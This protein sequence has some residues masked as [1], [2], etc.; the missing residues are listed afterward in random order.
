M[1]PGAHGPLLF[2]GQFSFQKV[3]SL[4]EAACAQQHPGPDIAV[5]DFLAVQFLSPLLQGHGLVQKPLVGLVFRHELEDARLFPAVFLIPVFQSL[6]Q[7]VGGQHGLDRIQV[8]LG[9]SL[10]SVAEL[11]KILALQED[12]P[13]PVQNLQSLLEHALQAQHFPQVEIELGIACENSFR[14]FLQVSVEGVKSGQAQHFLP[15]GDEHSCRALEV[16]RLEQVE[17]GQVRF[18]H[19]GA[20][21]RRAPMQLLVIV[22]TPTLFVEE[23]PHQMVVAVEIRGQHKDKQALLVQAAED[24]LAVLAAQELVADIDLQ[25]FQNGG[26]Q[27]KLLNLRA[28]IFQHLKG[29]VLKEQF[30]GGGFHPEHLIQL[31]SL[32][33]ALAQKIQGDDPAL[34]FPGRL[35]RFP[36]G[37]GEPILIRKE[38]RDLPAGEHQILFIDD[39]NQPLQPPT[40]PLPKAQLFPCG[41]NEVEPGRQQP[42]QVAHE[43]Q[44]L[45][46]GRHQVEVIHN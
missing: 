22:S 19:G 26:L 31:S 2:R 7:V 15:A 46:V 10:G 32:G 36:G 44:D 37:D 20:D 42:H 27:Q 39:Q 45:A 3:N 16:F 21:F 9:D 23:F 4:R 14:Q 5:I 29:Q 1:S 35:L 28:L 25:V 11:Q 30:Q 18:L 17:D 13:G 12:L 33:Q 6:L 38:I 43:L 24:L 40:G 8:D 34:R 41:Q